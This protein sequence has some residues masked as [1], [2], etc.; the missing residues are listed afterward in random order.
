MRF[1]FADCILDVD[2]FE[3]QRAGRAVPVQPKVLRLLLFL[4]E[5]RER[6]LAKSE[7]LDAVWPGVAT[8]EGSLT[9]AVSFAR[10]ALGETERDGKVIKTVRGRGYGIGVPVVVESAP[11]P[12]EPAEAPAT[13]DFLC[14]DRELA[15]ARDALHAA[16]R[17]RGQVLLLVGEAGIGKTRLAAELAGVAVARGAHVLWGRCHRG[18]AGR[19]FW[20][21]AQILRACVAECGADALYASLGDHAAEVAEYLPEL[22]ERLPELPAPA[23]DPGEALRRFFDGVARMLTIHAARVPLVVVLDD[24]HCADEPSLRLL[25]VLARDLDGARILVVGTYRDFEVSA[26]P[27]LLDTLAELARL[28]HPRRM[29]LLRGLTQGCVR[30]FLQGMSGVEPS[31]ALV[32]ACHARTEGN[33]LFLLELLQWMQG[34]EGPPGDPPAGLERE[35]PEGIRYVIRERLSGLSEECRRIL[36]SASVMG[37]E[38]SASV[39]ARVS[40]LSED[41]LLLRLEE[42]EAARAVEAVRASPGRLRFT[43]P[44]IGETLYDELSTRARAGLHRRVG[45]VLEELYTPR[46]LAPSNLRVG[47]RGEHLAELAHHFRESLPV[48]D[49]AKAIDYCER[50]GDRA[51]A[52]LAFHEAVGHYECALGVLDAAEPLDEERRARLEDAVAAA[53]R[54]A[55]GG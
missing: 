16:L 18:E 20:P 1:R 12:G 26:R 31:P 11:A 53:R 22:R 43:H 15:L 51:L 48:G 4:L 38:F 25:R 7:I 13:G 39:L 17:G 3:L 28:H 24:L 27:P 52:V 2:R 8:T 46:P 14:R 30:R 50:A 42:A 6:T 9:R 54:R 45:E 44:L 34:R 19:A 41:A 32:E 49:A 10:A 23:G 55:A 21:W 5:N 36:A 40:G 33:P 29:I 47:I 37:R 35:I